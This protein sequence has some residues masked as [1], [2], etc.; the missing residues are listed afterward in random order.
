MNDFLQEL[1]R[2]NVI[3]VAAAYAA[4]AWLIV[5]VAET[6]IPAYE[7]DPAIL[8]TTITVLIIG[9]FPAV[10]LAWVFEWTPDGLRRDE[11][12]SVSAAAGLR[13]AKRLDRVILVVLVIAVTYFAIDKFTGETTDTLTVNERSI[14]VMPFDNMSSDPEQEFL[15]DGVAGEI[16]TLLTRIPELRVISRASSIAVAG[17]NVPIADIARQLNVAYVLEGAV[18]RSGDQL[19]IE[20][21][22]NDSRTDSQVWAHSYDREMSDV[23]SIQDEIASDV[24]TRLRG[25]L[26]E[27]MPH[28]RTT[29]PKVYELVLRARH[30]HQ[31]GGGSDA[32][33]RA[34]Q[35]LQEAYRL[36]PTY[37]PAVIELATSTYMTVVRGVYPREKGMQEV[38]R[39][40]TEAARIDA[41]DPMFLVTTGYGQFARFGDLEGAVS[42]LER[43]IASAPGDVFVLQI[44]GHFASEVYQFDTAVRLHERTVELDPAC[45]MC[46]YFVARAHLY[47]R[48]YQ[49]AL[50]GTRE[51][52]TLGGGGAQ[53]LGTIYLLRGEP[54]KAYDAFAGTGANDFQIPA[55]QAMALHDMGR[56]DEANE[57]LARQLAEYPEHPREAARAYAWIGDADQ[58]FHFLDL[59]IQKTPDLFK[60]EARN[61]VWQNI[62]TDPRWHALRE[63]NGISEERIAAISFNPA[64]PD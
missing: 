47:A 20:A 61:P 42:S 23:F 13:N 60:S 49:N 5:Q 52:M 19:R 45:F 28:S 58:A 15:S 44:A 11:S 38:E 24:V 17:D 43:A 30:L 4:V 1:R 54:E 62:A 18:R 21:V 55:G 63:S 27:E 34:L 12:G 51:Y 10:I 3:R 25:S 64:L 36:D 40:M 14:V 39:L 35:L 37:L 9:L 6:V 57:M 53:T 29:T 41:N 7:L 50:E 33:V 46:V 22:L 2:R 48:D 56:I 59:A 31:S 16:R 8:R 26:L 32:G